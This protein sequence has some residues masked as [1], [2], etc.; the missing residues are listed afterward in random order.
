M[1]PRTVRRNTH[2][3]VA[4]RCEGI[5]ATATPLCPGPA[6]VM[7]RVFSAVA[8]NARLARNADFWR[9]RRGRGPRADRAP[10]VGGR[11]L[12]G[13]G[14]RGCSSAWRGDVSS[15]RV[16]AGGGRAAG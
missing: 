13:A 4:P 15:V 1:P 14:G 6:F 10:R 12:G 3:Q 5:L 11:A 2:P 8:L 16:G 7:P 9:T